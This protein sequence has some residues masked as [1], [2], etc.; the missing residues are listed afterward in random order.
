M[1]LRQLVISKKIE[2]RKTL[3]EEL[4]TQETTLK[5]RAAEAEKSLD[6][7]KTEEEIA[8]VEEENNKLDKEQKELDEKKSKLEGEISALESELEQINSNDPKD[9]PEEK[10]ESR[11][12]NNN[13]NRREGGLTMTMKRYRAFKNM[14][15]SEAEN[16]VTRAEVKDFL[17]RTRE[18][19]SQQRGITG[20]E[21]LIPDIMLDM[22]RDNISEY[23][24]LITK[25][26]YK[27]VKGKARQNITGTVPEAVW[28][29]MLGA[30]NELEI[31][32]NQVEVDGYMVGGFVIIPNSIM[33]DS[34]IALANEVLMQIGKAIGKALDKAI[35]YGIGVK[36][37]LGI[38]TRLAQTSK[39]GSYLANAPEWKDLHTTHITKVNTTGTGLV[40]S[41]ITAFALCK[42]DYSDGNK[43]FCMNTI[44]YA[45][46]ISQLLAF[47]AAG[48]IV[49]GM[50]NQMPIIGGD[51]VTLDF[52]PN[53]DIIGGYGDLY[54]LAEREGTSLA[55]SE[56]VKFIQNQTVFK[57]L[58]RY[59]GLPVI[60]EGF[61]MININNIDATTETEFEF[62]Y[63]N[64][65]L[66]ALAVVSTADPATTGK[67]VIAFTGGEAS[68]TTYGYKVAGK[69]ANVNCGDKNT[70]FTTIATG[71]SITA[72]TGK[73]ITVVEFDEN[74]RAIKIG[75]AQIIAKA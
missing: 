55:S 39:P 43:F 33:Q 34:D 40:A 15:R 4:N 49:T 32:F 74:N 58:A 54:I 26:N 69:A 68:G 62:D 70:G 5:V 22:L 51:I 42:N 25:V 65:E 27:P 29:E 50:N 41:V 75:S 21:L 59:D 47:N 6:E 1:A 36:Q 16:L 73:I 17:T 63:A 67:T 61:F 44:T 66:G 52:I 9:S 11:E 14:T 18:F 20:A 38:A 2:Q 23:S 31:S 28:T 48:A 60:A 37:P 57:G 53:Y 30:L 24:K 46:L 19:M 72:A 56:H 7:A 35:L 71:A 8:L 13:Q 3:L 45:Y 10:P 12:K 64:T